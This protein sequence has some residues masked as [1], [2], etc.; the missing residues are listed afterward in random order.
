M[1]R[2]SAVPSILRLW[3][4][5]RQEWRHHP[6][7]HALVALA[8]ALGVALA[9]SVQ[10]INDSA[11]AEFGA[12]VRSANGEPDLSLRSTGA[13]FDDAL[14]DRVSLHAGV[15][16]ASPVVEADTYVVLDSR[17]VAVRLLGVDGLRVAALAAD[18]LPVAGPGEDRLAM[19]DP[20]AAFA[21]ASARERLGLAPGAPLRLQ[22]GPGL[23][24]LRLAGHVAAPGP[25]L[26]VMDVAA[27]QAL[28]GRPGRLDRLDLR[29]EPGTDPAALARELALPAGVR[30][31]QRGESEQRLSTLS[32]AYRINLTVLALVSL[33]VGG[34]LVFSVVMLSVAQRTP[35]LALLGVLGLSARERQR[36]V[37]AEC[38]LLGALGSLAGLALGLG[39]AWA[40]LR[41]LGGD[42]GGGFFPGV[43]PALSVRPL[44]ALG[45][46]ALG[47]A[48][49]L[50]GG[51]VPARQAA[52]LAP[53]QALKGLGD[54]HARRA[55][56][57]PALALLV[58]GAA[59]ALLPPVG[60]VP[61]AAYASVACLLL[62][63]VGLVPAVVQA[64]LTERRSPRH[65]LVLL[66]RRRAAHQ[67]ATAGAAV[68]GVVASLALSVALTVMVASFRDSVSA[69]LD[70]VLP[71]DL[72]ARSAG[73]SG[74]ADQ[75]WFGPELPQRL[76]Q[77]PELRRVH[78]SR[79][80]ALSLS[81][82]RPGVALIARPLPDPLR[83]LPLQGPVATAAPG[84]LGVWVS[85][86]VVALHG[87]RVGGTLELPLG[88]RRVTVRVLGVWRDFARQFGSIAIDHASYL[89]LTGDTRLNELA[90][91][92]AP[93]AEAPA[94]QT[95]IR[96]LLPDPALLDFAA[97]AEL[98]RISLAIFDR[99]F[100]VTVYLQAVA[101]VIGLVGIA[102]SLSAQVL[103]R[104][105]EFGLLAHLGLTRRQVMAL[106]TGETASWLAAGTLL[107]LLLGLAV[108]L[109]LVYV[110][111]PQSFHWTMDLALPLPRLAALCAAVVVA[112]L[113][114]AAWAGRR[115]LSRSAVLAVKEDW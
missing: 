21:N 78:A 34:F 113:A 27:A 55:R 104:R 20:Q 97:T 114:T 1:A 43:Q 53:A 51:W 60:G 40:A 2:R 110:V 56:V 42:L 85:E 11:L 70:G 61:V 64:L 28:L 15:R 23:A 84:E 59:L 106:V 73:S 100:A 81:P 86:G 96:Q 108:S 65:A 72:Y 93:G 105:K 30:V 37:L 39:A 92:L 102:T 103:A 14:L 90:L 89:A 32:R 47:V 58:L 48:T 87:A 31:A 95:A 45:C 83:Q 18:L 109:V 36:L 57:G 12:A 67:R 46:F 22:S 52:G 80:R 79:V 111:N 8:V 63:G 94:V 38:A 5:V 33:F 25:P 44:V 75:A 50:A 7:R 16:L 77:M 3:P 54:A 82:D 69:W 115:A 24:T 98:R 71:A 76:S 68:A 74:A 35:T 112:G 91:W 66:A 101:I 17:R 41:L 49:A 29:L 9:F 62:G 13:G 6:W 88:E 10:V 26:L 107:G 4:L 99:S 19:L